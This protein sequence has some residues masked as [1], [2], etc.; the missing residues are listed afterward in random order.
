MGRVAWLC[1][2]ARVGGVGWEEGGGEDRGGEGEEVEGD[3]EEFVE[4]AEDE[5]DGLSGSVILSR[6]RVCV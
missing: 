2:G 5:E 1:R 6:A 4:G 3:E